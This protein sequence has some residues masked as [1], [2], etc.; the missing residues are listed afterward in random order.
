M[1]HIK[2][3]LTTLSMAI[4]NSA[5][6]VDVNWKMLPNSEEGERQEQNLSR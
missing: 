4:N 2:D 3:I 1:S 6:A 5:C